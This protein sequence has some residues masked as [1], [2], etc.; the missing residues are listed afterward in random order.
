M[1]I[2]Y[3]RSCGSVRIQSHALV[4]RRAMPS[5]GRILISVLYMLYTYIH[6]SRVRYNITAQLPRNDN[7][8]FIF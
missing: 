8:N 3:T 7:F 2:L 4:N 5:A 6:A 1:Y